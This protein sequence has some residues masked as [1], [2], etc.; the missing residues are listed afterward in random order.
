[1]IGSDYP[2][3]DFNSVA[4]ANIGEPGG[5]WIPETLDETV[6]KCLQFCRVLLLTAI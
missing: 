5:G 4:G 3:R 2:M 1:M 6:S